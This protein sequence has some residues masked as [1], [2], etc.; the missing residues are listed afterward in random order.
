[1][2]AYK[3]ITVLLTRSKGSELNLLKSISAYESRKEQ[4]KGDKINIVSQVADLPTIRH[5]FVCYGSWL[6]GISDENRWAN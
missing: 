1:M 6:I 5:C 2:V 3:L 4:Q